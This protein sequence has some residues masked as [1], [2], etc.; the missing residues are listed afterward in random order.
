MT[1]VWGKQK[2]CESATMMQASEITARNDDY[3][4][5]SNQTCEIGMTRATGKQYLHII[6]VLEELSR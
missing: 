1:D 6:E 4:V 2:C 5:S 3:Y